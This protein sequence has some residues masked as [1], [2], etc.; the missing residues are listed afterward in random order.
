MPKPIRTIEEFYAHAL[1]L[2]HEAAERYGEFER[3][4]RDRG[5]DVLAGLCASLSQMEGEHFSQ[6][7]RASEHLQLPVIEAEHYQWLESGAPEAAAREVLYRVTNPRHLLEIALQAEHRAVSFFEWVK[8]SAVDATVRS[9]ATEMA[10]EEVQHVTWVQNA[11]DYHPS[12]HVDWERL[13]AR[14]S[15]PGALVGEGESESASPQERV[16][17]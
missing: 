13:I 12:S 11:L 3:Y 10:A 6:L 16:A 14:G 8:H 2:E 1:A 5:E 4:F 9:L 7:V 15:G 17:S